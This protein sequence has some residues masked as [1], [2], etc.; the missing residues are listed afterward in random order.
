MET[1]KTKRARFLPERRPAGSAG[2]GADEPSARDPA[3]AAALACRNARA[4][5][6]FLRFLLL[7]I[8]VVGGAI[9][10]ALGWQTYLGTI[11][12]AETLMRRSA[13]IAH[14]HVLTVLETQEFALDAVLARAAG[15][16][17]GDAAGHAEITGFLGTLDITMEQIASIW[18]IN[19]D[20]SVEAASVSWEPGTNASD[21][22]DFQA[23]VARDAGTYIGRAYLRRASGKRSFSL[24]RR[25]TG[26]DGV[27]QGIVSISMSADY[28]EKFFA[29]TSEG[30]NWTAALVRAD[31]EVLARDPSLPQPF[32]Y[33]SDDALL[34]AFAT[35][36]EGILWR[37]SPADGVMRLYGYRRIGAYPLYVVLATDRSSVMHAWL[38]ALLLDSSTIAAGMAAFVIATLLALVRAKREHGALERLVREIVQRAEAES[39]LR[40]SQKM[41][42][43]GRLTTSLAHDFRNVLFGVHVHLENFLTN[44]AENPRAR[45]LGKQI[46]VEVRRAD[47]LVQSLLAFARRQPLEPTRFDVNAE[48]RKLERLLRKFCGDK[49][50]LEIDCAAG[51]WHALADVNQMESAVINLVINACDAMPDGGSVRIATANVSLAGQPNGLVGDFVAISVSDT[52]I[53]MPPEILTRAF[54]PFFTT[55]QPGD[56]T[57]LGLSSVLDFAAQSNGTVTLSS[58]PER[59]TQATLYIPR[60]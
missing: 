42:S 28:F 26:P 56:G 50:S 37:K 11:E 33:P 40:Q 48:I 23:Q 32:A 55:K 35:R 41:E 21:R 2:Q 53:G 34:R 39:R 24:S 13:G 59:G 60:S 44:A 10:A 14:Q 46:V 38:D 31:G 58:T 3:Y 49:V 45:D 20:G 51:M 47:E 5:I 1:I 57:G 6:R 15:L 29:Q 54:E 22:D 36:P 52:G 30:K 27:F 8:F 9:F 43:L 12:N 16:R 4:A 7:A 17:T 25:R 19:A 18:L